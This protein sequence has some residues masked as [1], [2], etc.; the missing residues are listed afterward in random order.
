[1]TVIQNYK[2]KYVHQKCGWKGRKFMNKII[3][4]VCLIVGI[5]LL[6]TDVI[7]VKAN[8][9]ESRIDSSKAKKWEKAYAKFLLNKG[10]DGFNLLY[11]DSGKVPVLLINMPNKKN[12][13]S[14]PT[15]YFYKYKKGKVKKI[16]KHKQKMTDLVA[17]RNKRT[18]IFEEFTCN[19][20]TYICKLKKGKIKKVKYRA[21]GRQEKPYGTDYYKEN[22][23]ISRK[24]YDRAINK[25]KKILFY[26]GDWVTI[27][28]R[29]LH[30]KSDQ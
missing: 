27:W 28:V 25:K 15:Y 29:L 10:T 21:V 8:T 19:S 22:K 12:C 7:D 13:N 30:Q 17:Y 3:R 4:K 18:I 11:M 23:K 1:M 20:E 16:G 14:F 2:I 9:L 5:V 6:F 24:S 26:S